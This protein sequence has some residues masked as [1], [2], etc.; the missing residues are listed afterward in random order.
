MLSTRIP[1]LG[2]LSLPLLI[3]VGWVDLPAPDGIAFFEKRV[4]P[5][6]VEHC[7]S[8]HSAT[9][10]AKVRGELR[11]DTR[12]GVLK[13][14]SSGPAIVPGHP[15]KSL[16]IKAIRHTDELKMPPKAPLSREQ[17]SDLVA[18]VKMGAP[19]PREGKA[20]TRIDLAKGKSFWS[21]QPV[22]EP[23]LPSVRDH[24]WPL[25]A[26]D[27]FVLA[28]QE[29]RGLQPAPM[30]DRRTLIR[31]LTYD[32]TGLPPTP[33]EIATFLADTS[34]NAYDR[35]VERLL[36]STAYGERWGRRWLD[37]VRYA[38]TAGD[39]SDY[40]IPQHYRYRNWVLDA[41]NA[42]MP[43]DRFVREQ[44]AGDL[45]EGGSEAEQRD[46]LIATGYVANTRRF[47]SY[48]DERYQWYLTYEDTIDNLSRAFLGMTM[49]C[50]RCHDHKFD[51]LLTTDYYALYGFFSSTRYPWPGI[52]LDKVQRDLVPLA[53]PEE[54]ARWKDARDAR[55]NELEA[56][57][58][59]LQA[60]KAPADAIKAARAERDAF[61]KKPAPFDL[62]YAVAEGKTA[63]NKVVGNARIQMKGDPERLGDEVPRRFPLVLGGQTL[64]TGTTGSGR[65]H[66]ANWL[67]EPSNPRTARVLVNRIWQGHFGRGIVPTPNDFGTMGQPPSHPELLDYLASRL[68]REGWSIKAL[69]RLIVRSRTYQLSGEENPTNA[70][71]DAGNQYLWRFPRQRLDAEAIRDTLLT[72]G[73]NL[74]RSMGQAHPFPEMAKWNFTQHNPF[75]AVYETNRRSVYLMTQRIQRHPFLALFDGPDTNASTA[76]R[77]TSTTPLQS[78]FLMNDP[79]VHE[80]ARRFAERLLREGKDDDARLKRGYLLALGR[81]PTAEEQITLRSYLRQIRE[82]VNGD[83]QKVWESVTR[84]LFLSNELVYID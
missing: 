9:P 13:G 7:Y 30:A 70:G 81:L 39:N 60:A 26:V 64:P 5:I 31:R 24:A 11:L 75:K 23:P 82:K 48:E 62:I 68:V 6:L 40:P 42:D 17:V 16:L 58:K 21:Y 36:A 47:G 4:R 43:Y 78:L 54:V 44:L 3:P 18:W 33:E 59:K 37:V 8:C 72:L 14:G 55:L 41:F 63:G 56:R 83:N 25:N 67:T 66:L 51:P 1:L 80:Q 45:I 20:V 19:D 27:H 34:P 29:R 38:D 49:G 57:L 35:V 84:A 28:E 50:A 52:E 69:H 71:I 32:L 46:R 22:V 76:S 10:G 15:E 79:F 2:F 65:L 77:I 12:E 61:A 74:D 73:E 53:S